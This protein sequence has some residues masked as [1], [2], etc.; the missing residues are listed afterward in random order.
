MIRR[1]LLTLA[2]ATLGLTALTAPAHAAPAAAPRVAPT[3]CTTSVEW[4][5]QGNNYFQGKGN[6]QCATGRYRAKN[7]C[8]N[9]QTGQGYVVYGTQ[10]AN[11][12]ATAS[13]IC[14]T[15]NVA[16]TVQAVEDPLPTGVGVTGCAPWMEWV[17]E[18]NNIYYGRGRVQCDTGRYKIQVNCH[19]LQTGQL[20]TVY[21][22]QV[23]DAPATVT[24]T[25][26][27]GNVAESVVAVPQ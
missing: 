20:Y 1:S 3:G 12:P 6:V 14:N 27:Q 26:N 8:Q 7:V 19:N 9:L 10:V 18:G 24:T 17:V 4:V 11:A 21:G 5:Q 2:A 23:V 15:G 13:V 22:A 16:G 25:C